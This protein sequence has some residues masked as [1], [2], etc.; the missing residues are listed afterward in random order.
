MSRLGRVGRA[1]TH[2]KVFL[3]NH[4]PT[5][6]ERELH[7]TREEERPN[8]HRHS[9]KEPR[10]ENKKKGRRPVVLGDESREPSS[11]LRTRRSPPGKAQA[12][13]GEAWSAKADDGAASSNLQTVLAKM[14][15][16]EQR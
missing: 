12:P 7:T 3:H 10:V 5:P 14:A 13:K 15:I 4:F 2:S 9:L 6:Q 8:P 11:T 1:G 16:E